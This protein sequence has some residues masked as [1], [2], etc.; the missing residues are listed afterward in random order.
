MDVEDVD[1]EGCFNVESS[2]ATAELEELAREEAIG[3]TLYDKKWVIKTVLSLGSEDRNSDELASLVDMTVE[4]DVCDFLV[5]SGC[6]ELIVGSVSAS[7]DVTV[8]S[9]CAAV[10][11]NVASRT[12]AAAAVGSALPVVVGLLFRSSEPGSLSCAFSFLKSFVESSDDV[13]VIRE[14]VG[15]LFLDGDFVHRVGFILGV[16]SNGDVLDSASR[17]LLS[18]FDSGFERLELGEEFEESGYAKAE[19]ACACAEAMKECGVRS[20]AFFRLMEVVGVVC[21]DEN[22][23]DCANSLC[24]LVGLRLSDPEEPVTSETLS[25]AAK[26]LWH[27]WSS[28]RHEDSWEKLK[29]AATRIDADSDDDSERFQAAKE[30][31]ERCLCQYRVWHPD[32][33]GVPP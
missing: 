13:S 17:F 4:R 16:S 12:G 18:L 31:V 20:P 30:N 2:D 3:S 5:E 1:D 8:L 26:V 11:A 24:D 22:V 32:K 29:S 25:L 9:N 14:A 27:C 15:Q 28:T 23:V 19:F 7:E 10:M 6:M 33:D 21:N